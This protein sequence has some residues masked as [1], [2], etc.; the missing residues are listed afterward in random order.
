MSVT[1]KEGIAKCP[2]TVKLQS[3]IFV[4]ERSFASKTTET[5]YSYQ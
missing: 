2:V 1:G 4:M 3:V 5:V